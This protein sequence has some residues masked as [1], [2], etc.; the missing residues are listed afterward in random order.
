MAFDVRYFADLARIAL[1]DE[2]IPELEKQM[3]DILEFVGQLAELD[4]DDVQPTEH[5]IPLKNV[6]RQDQIAA[7]LPLQQALANMPEVKDDSLKT[8]VIIE[9]NES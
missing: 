1:H 4:L 2:E 6:V 9:D 8:P 5:V 7:S 3:A